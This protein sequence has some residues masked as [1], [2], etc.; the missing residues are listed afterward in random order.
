[1]TINI[2]KKKITT[3]KRETISVYVL[4]DGIVWRFTPKHFVATMND[5]INY[6]RYDLS[7]LG[8]RTPK[9]PNNMDMFFNMDGSNR[10]DWNY[11]KIKVSVLSG[12]YHR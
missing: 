7:S 9:K 11:M 2:K 6:G 12:L 5:A 8:K 1:M 4:S 3:K 10:E